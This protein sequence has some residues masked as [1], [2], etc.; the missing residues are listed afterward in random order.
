MMLRDENVGDFK[1]WLLPKLD[2]MYAQ[3]IHAALLPV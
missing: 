2:K 1:T 3:T